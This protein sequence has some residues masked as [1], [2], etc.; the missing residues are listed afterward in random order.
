MPVLAGLGGTGKSIVIEI[1]ASMYARS[2]VGT[3]S[4]NHEQ[5]FGL[6]SKLDCEVI[7]GRDMPQKMGAVL[8]QE[9]LQVMVTGESI[10]VPRKGLS[11]LDVPWTSHMILGTNFFVFIYDNSG[12]QISRRIVTFPFVHLVADPDPTLLA[13]IKSQELP[14]IIARVLTA[15]HAAT[16]AHGH[17]DFWK[18]CPEEL[19]RSQQQT[20]G[21]MSA[22]KR[23]LS[24]GPDDDARAYLRRDEGSHVS[25][26]VL[27]AA[28]N[29][30]VT[31]QRLQH[32]GV[33]TSEVMNEDVVRLAGFEVEDK[34]KTCLACGNK[35][36]QCCPAFSRDR[37]TSA[38]AVRGLQLVHVEDPLGD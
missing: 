11:A 28:Y 13:R 14:A 24:L 33:R 35:V 37:R 3:L 17:V 1:V 9:M 15:Y 27:V 36:R 21:A 34:V 31:D 7:I 20:A 22:V 38:K 23:F 16:A 18:W 8:P 26:K 25:L 12:G 4:T 29:A 10:S 19:R 32:P 5:V 30:Y 6:Q 2:Q